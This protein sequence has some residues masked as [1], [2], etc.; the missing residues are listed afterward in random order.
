MNTLLPR[1]SQVTAGLNACNQVSSFQSQ[2]HVLPH[3]AKPCSPLARYDLHCKLWPLHKTLL[4]SEHRAKTWEVTWT[5]WPNIWALG[6]LLFSALRITTLWQ[7]SACWFILSIKMTGSTDC[8]HLI[9]FCSSTG[10]GLFASNK[11]F[12]GCT[13]SSKP[14]TITTFFTYTLFSVFIKNSLVLNSNTSL[15]LVHQHQR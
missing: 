15:S 7:D 3:W 4:L 12:Q 11:R 2:S 9:T 8:Y 10:T 5:N 14:V 13:A 6:L 1:H